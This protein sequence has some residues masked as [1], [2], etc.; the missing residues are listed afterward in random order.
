PHEVD[1]DAAEL[2]ERDDQDDDDRHGPERDPCL[3]GH[4]DARQRGPHGHWATPLSNG[5]GSVSTYR[6]DMEFHESP[7]AQRIRRKGRAHPN[8]DWSAA[9][10]ARSLVCRDEQIVHSV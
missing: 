1:V 6:A 9:G 8:S 3:F 7:A 10:Q 5:T 4:P 2:N